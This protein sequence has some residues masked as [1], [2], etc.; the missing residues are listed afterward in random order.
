MGRTAD[1]ARH[2]SLHMLD[3]A[4][5]DGDLT[6][7]PVLVLWWRIPRKYEHSA[8]VLPCVGKSDVLKRQRTLVK[9]QIK[10]NTIFSFPGCIS[11]NF[12]IY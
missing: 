11:K 10:P 5:P 4:T 3:A 6:K 9:F 7:G 2:F 8:N 12:G 1:P